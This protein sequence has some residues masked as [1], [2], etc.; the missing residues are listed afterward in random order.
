MMS[1]YTIVTA[2]AFTA[3]MSTAILAAEQVTSPQVPAKAQPAPAAAAATTGPKMMVDEPLRDFGSVPK[4]QK[5]DWTFA[6][7]NTGTADLE[8]LSVQPGCGCTVAEFDK[9]IKPGQT[10]KIVAH[11]DTT[12]F[13]GP[14]SKFVTVQSNDPSL[15]SSQL[16]I[17][18]IVKPYVEA[19]PTGFARYQMLQGEAQTATL[20]LYSEEEAPFEIT[21]I[22]TPG[23]WVK[24][25]WKKITDDSERVQAGRPGQNQYQID[26]QVAGPETPIGPLAHK[27]HVFTNSKFQPD[28]P[29]SIVGVIR[30][31]VNITPTILN[32]GEV[33]PGDTASVRTILLNTND[34]RTPSAFQVTKVESNTP[35]AFDATVKATEKPGEYEVEVKLAKDAKPGL[36]DGNV[37]IFTSDKIKPV[38]TVPVKGTVKKAAA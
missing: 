5:L 28:Y 6:V 34:K 21:R 13:S 26:I 31:T 9:V 12:N 7:K 38:I 32:F 1:K 18:A 16:T 3:T 2:L 24:A 11:V 17:H 10:G 23:N 36:I 19:Y 15:P 14:I 37:K 29:I 33:A 8:L 22:E 30:P 35:A 20:K 4:G 27:V 25:G